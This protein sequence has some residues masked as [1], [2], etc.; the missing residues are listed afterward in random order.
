MKLD[1]SWQTHDLPY[2]STAR[3]LPNLRHLRAVQLVGQLGSVNRAAGMMNLS[4]PAV[5]QAIARL[6]TQVAPGLF[7]RHPT[8]MY[9][10]PAGQVLLGRIDRAFTELD[11][12][13]NAISAGGNRPQADIQLKAVQ[14]DA[15]AALVHA[16]GI[17]EAAGSL[18]ITPTAFKR[19]I[20]T[21]EARLDVPL[22]FRDG[23]RIRLTR[24]GDVLAR[25]ARIVQREI[26]LAQDEIASADG[27][28]TGRLS[29]GALPLARSYIV[30]KAMIEV[31]T[32]HPQVRLR[33][34]E[35]SYEFLLD[36]LRRGDIDL[37]VGTLREP[38]PVDDVSETKLFDDQ[39][40]VVGRTDHPLAGTQG[41]TLE[42]V[43][44]YPWI[45]P[46]LGSPARREFDLMLA[47]AVTSPPQIFEVASHMSVRTILQ[48]SDSLALVSRRQI[49]YEE[50]N[51]QLLVL[52]DSLASGTR[53]IGYTMRARSLPTRV[54]QEF[55]DALGRAAKDD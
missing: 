12:A 10:T 42:R 3:R 8:G 2:G 31:G 51:G 18:G 21:L 17:A 34:V 33:L 5:T 7:I 52:S 36:L 32:R 45:A 13:L 46:R 29:I 50:R 38:A 48:E 47:R 35:G 26:E 16:S 4:Q 14:L 28:L 20:N 6:E 9:A 19:N 55:L 25:A 24:F 39:L 30:P 23:N 1:S 27:R 41:L 40:C 53:S 11:T 54:T 37:F 49:R 44:A 43:M 15:L 22:V